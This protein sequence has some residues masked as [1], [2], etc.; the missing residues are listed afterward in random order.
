MSISG[1]YTK[2]ETGNILLSMDW[3]SHALGPI[4]NWPLELKN[5]L[6]LIFNSDTAMFVYWGTESF[7]F[8]NDSTI[9]IVGPTR[10]PHI[11]GK[12]GIDVWPEIFEGMIKPQIES[13]FK[14]QPTW[15]YN[16]FVPLHRGGTLQDG[17][18]TN[19]Y[20]PIYSIDGKING[21]LVIALET[22]TTTNALKISESRFKRISEALPQLVWTCDAEGNCIYLSKQWENYTGMPQESQ[23]GFSW[24]EKVIHPDDKA[25]TFDHWMGAVKG[26]HPYDIEY[27]IKGADGNYRWFKNTWNAH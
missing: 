25:R 27:R 9:P 14:G 8:Y 16:Q 3:S 12:K 23:L 4:E 26:L 7:C 18:F 19:G 20:S 1:I 24:L 5:I 22:T 17:Y 10:H 13:V 6:N 2:Q 15:Q 21:A 11:L